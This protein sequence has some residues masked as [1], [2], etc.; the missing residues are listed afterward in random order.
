MTRCGLAT[1]VGRPNVG[2]STL[3]NA[4][5]DAKV[6]IAARTPNTTRHVIRGID[7][8]G[9]CQ[10]VYLD[11][12]GLHR[13]KTALG[14]RLNAA[15]RAAGED[16]DAILALV[17]A[18]APIGD[19]DRE[20]LGVLTAVAERSK[21]TRPFVV[22]NKVDRASRAATVAHL[23][24]LAGLVEELSPTSAARAE[25]FPLSALRGE[26]VSALRAAVRAAMPEG[27]F[28]F[29]E[30]EVSDQ[31]AT[32]HIA[33][34]VRE[35]LLRHLRDELPHAVHCRVTAYEWPH[36]TVEILVERD[37]QKGIVIGKGGATLKAVGTAARRELPE[38][39]YLELV[40]R[41]ESDWQRRADTLDRLGY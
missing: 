19:G 12:P 35:Q 36:V 13:P 2:K 16:V 40:V 17:D 25:Y 8:E 20:A 11:T 7:T 34:L 9:D 39:T 15:A 22:V 30:D 31:S 24:E 33:E 1:I 23:A 41:V 27:H 38:G 18:T 5:V 29:P 26:G 10:V 14:E 21:A 37:S 28:L 3:L 4:L 32:S 6:S